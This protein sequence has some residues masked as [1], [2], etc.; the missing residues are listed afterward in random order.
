MFEVGDIVKIVS[1]EDDGLS[2]IIA[3]STAR[4]TKKETVIIGSYELYT[5][6]FIDIKDE[7]YISGTA[8]WRAKNLCYASEVKDV[9]ESDI[10][11]LLSGE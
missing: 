2:Q 9:S 11:N 7:R 1:T 8:H 5:I 4:I 3:G 6:S 10:M